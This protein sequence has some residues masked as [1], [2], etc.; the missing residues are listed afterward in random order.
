LRAESR[1]AW[2]EL[3]EDGSAPVVVRKG[4][5]NYLC[6]LNLEDAIQGGFAGRAAILAQLVARW[7]AFTRDGD[8]IGGDLPGWLGTLYRQRGIAALTDR[9]GECVYAGCPHYRKCFIERASRASVRADLVIA[10]HALVMVNAARGRDHAAR[11]TRIVFD[12]GHHVFDAADSTFAAALTGA[13]AI[14]LRR[15]VIGPEK[16]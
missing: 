2:G 3:R 16:A 10:N 1:R 9:R 12:E 6:L 8:M 7:A 4:R 5:E 14:E 15:W 11:P 13:E